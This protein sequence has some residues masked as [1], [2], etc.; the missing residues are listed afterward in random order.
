[1]SACIGLSAVGCRTFTATSSQG[2]A[3]M[4]EILFI[5]SALRLPIVMTT[6]NRALSGPINIWGD[7]SDVMAN[8]DIG[9]VQIFANNGQE[10]YDLTPCAFRIAEDHRVL[11]PVMLNFDG[12]TVSHVVEP[13]ETLTQ[14]DV[15]D[16]LPPFVPAMRLDPDRPISMGPV[17]PPEIYTEAKKAQN[18]VLIASRAVIDEVFADF[19]RR[20]G[21]EYRALETYQMD[22]AETVIVTMG[23]TIGETARVAVDDLR[24]RGEKVGQ[25]L[26]RVWRPFPFDD[27]RRLLDGRKM[28][29][30]YDRALSAGGPGGPVASEVRSAMYGRAGAPPVSS[31]IAALGGRDIRW[32]DIAEQV[33]DAREKA[34][35][36]EFADYTMVGVR[37]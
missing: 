27:L 31:L 12:F 18:D 33:L 37:E 22:D 5:A 19:G 36:G 29:V 4:H 26:F 13:M 23:G 32:R 6:V 3:L 14:A 25:V 24:S 35:K 16:F 9:W 34:D 2:L 10:A 30:V 21:R 7:L 8:R 1:M 15:D 20:F 11:L 17:G 28:V